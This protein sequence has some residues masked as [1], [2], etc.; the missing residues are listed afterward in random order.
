MS[1]L[2]L[3]FRKKYTI[4]SI[5][6]DDNDTYHVYEHLTDITVATLCDKDPAQNC[7]LSSCLDRERCKCGV[8]LLKFSDLEMRLSEDVPDVSWERYE[9]ISIGSKKKLTLVR[10]CTKLGIM[11]FLISPEQ[12][13][14]LY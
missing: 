12:F 14:D 9:Y 1:F 2:L 4:P 6:E 11:L 5:S 3:E 8:K 13:L 7:F 10:K